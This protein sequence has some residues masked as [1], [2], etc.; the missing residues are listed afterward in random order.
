METRK[1]SLKKAW[2][3]FVHD[4]SIDPTVRPVI[5]E[6][7][8]RSK[9]LGIDPNVFRIQRTAPDTIEKELSDQQQFINTSLS[10]MKNLF[11]F[12]QG[13]GFLISLADKNG[14]ILDL[15]GEDKIVK[16]AGTHIGDIWTEESLGTNSICL[17]LLTRA[18]IQVFA[19][20]HYL[21]SFHSWTCSSAPI[22]DE[23]GAI[24]GVLSMTGECDQV[25]LHTLGM[26]VAG[27][28]A[29]KDNLQMQTSFKQI[30]ISNTYKTAI[31]ESIDEGIVALTTE[32]AVTHINNTA[33]RILKIDR[34]MKEIV[35]TLLRQVL[36]SHHPLCDK[37]ENCFK[38]SNGDIFFMDEGSFT[39]THRLIH[40]RDNQIIGM[41]L[42][43]R[44]M[45]MMKK[46]V[47]GM[48]GARA[49]Y[50]FHD[51][52]GNNTKFKET[53]KLAKAAGN[54]V[55]N[56]LLL[57]ES[58]TGKEIFAQSIHNAGPR[59]SGPFLGI[60]CAALPRGLIESELFGYAEGAFT[61]AKKGGNPGKFE[62]ADGGTF[63]L[64]EIGEMSLDLQAILLRVLQESSIVRIG[65]KEIIPV[66]VRIIAAT[67]KDLLKEIKIGNFRRDL[68][69]RLNVLTINIPPLQKRKDD[70]ST[71]ATYFLNILN[72]RLNTNV[73]FISD[74]VLE[75]FGSY[76]WPGNIRELQ[77]ILER[78]INITNGNTIIPASLPEFMF[79]PN[80]TPKNIAAGSQVPLKEYE[81][82]LIISLL[83]E[84]NGNRAKVAKI[85]N[86][87]RTTLYRKIDDYNI[88]I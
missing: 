31:M 38:I 61:G 82:Q 79:S 74:E 5:A 69:Y 76:H 70:I 54:S 20:E 85:L 52:I 51:I 12:V 32:G 63:F 27:V 33:R 11:D 34:P 37:I 60:N 40:S 6:S 23:N 9:A 42:V 48:V 71:L 35:G 44:E 10:I 81:K 4:S 26:V 86:I 88:G 8:G 55:S 15:V 24:L 19:A 80:G 25:H 36:G 45:K 22:F 41:V 49:R 75:I 7:W 67:N 50:T 30:A 43:L 72:Q 62:L 83:E 59:R 64:D 21:T 84:H 68:Y 73:K 14:M 87:S 78:A 39:V 77:N 29:I 47:N 58:G 2:E 1:E 3:T 53:I 46:L 56:V 57:G 28:N 66:D 17:S 13:T 18:P 16:K 65:G